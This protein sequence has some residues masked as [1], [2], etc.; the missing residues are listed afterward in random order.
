[1]FALFT[2]ME[3]PAW[4]VRLADLLVAGSTINLSALNL[5]VSVNIYQLRA[6]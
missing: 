5:I 1:M 6:D 4:T 2:E 3:L